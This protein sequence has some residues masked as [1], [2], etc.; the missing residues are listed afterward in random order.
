MAQYE[1]RQRNIED[2]RRIQ[3]WMKKAGEGTAAYESMKERYLDLRATLSDAG[4]NL[5]ELDTL[6]ESE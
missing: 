6:H 2:F 3:G 1:I 4:V 5:D